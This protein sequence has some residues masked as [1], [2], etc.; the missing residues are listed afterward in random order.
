MSQMQYNPGAYAPLLS[1]REFAKTA[2]AKKPGA[3]WQGYKNFVT[4]TRMKRAAGRA[5]SAAADPSG[6]ALNQV[7]SGLLTPLQQNTQAT[8]LTN[9]TLKAQLAAIDAASSAQ[10]TQTSNQADRAQGF[11]LALA[12]LTAANPDAIA[13]E[14]R[15]TA[16]R[17]KGYG[18][19][20]TGAVADAENTAAN[21]TAQHLADQGLTQQVGSYD[22]ASLRNSLQIANVVNPA[23][24]LEGQAANAYAEA[25]FNRAAQS[26]Q[27]GGIAQD[28]LQKLDALRTSDTAQKDALQAGRP[29]AFLQA[30]SQIQGNQ[31][32]LLNTYI[33]GQYLQNSLGQANQK[34]NLLGTLDAAKSNS[35]GYQV[36]SYGQPIY[37]A[38]GNLQPIKGYKIG[39][40]GTPVKIPTA[41]TTTAKT[42]TPGEI[43]SYLG[44]LKPT[45]ATQ[46]ITT[47]D[48][49]GNSTSH[50]APYGAATYPV[51]FTAALK[52]LTTWG[53]MTDAEARQ[54][55]QSVYP[56]GTA[57]RGWL[58]NE[59]QA[60]LRKAGLQS[61]AGVKTVKGYAP[62]GFLTI[63]QHNALK[64][65]GMLPDGH[66]IYPKNKAGTM[67][68]PA[69]WVINH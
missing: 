39:A 38:N 34:T 20:L 49:N 67:D 45:Q 57:G 48:A 30:L 56:R 1:A 12:K 24:N 15:D 40:G 10:R 33:Q 14:Y 11:A 63:N 42:A 68:L 65:L 2:A 8:N 19:G 54:T 50:P 31:G 61:A 62:I 27:M 41:K 46:T 23:K 66:W 13:G 36:D 44:T 26:S 47:R 3:S 53:G 28:Y 25:Q 55:L 5:A 43:S 22:P 6:F 37:D 9:A 35:T 51:T 59:E 18:T 17:L 58:T 32:S 4:A 52:R 69:R 60:A 21:T 29:A 7:Q 16:D 64:G